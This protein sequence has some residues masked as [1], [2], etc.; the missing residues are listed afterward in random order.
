LDVRDLFDLSGRT[1]IV[2]GGGR[3][4]GRHIGVGLAEAGARVFLASRKL[5]NCEHAAAE[6]VDRGLVAEGVQADVAKPEEV[7]SLVDHVLERSDRIDVL[8]NNAGMVWAADTLDYPLKGWDRVFELNVRGLWLLSQR[9]ARQMR[10]Q[11]GGNIIHITSTSA[12]RGSFEEEQNVVAYN[13]SK[14]AVEALTKD[15]A[16]KLARYG[17]RVNAI[18]PG[19]FDTNMMDYMRQDPG[20]LAR[21]HAAI[22]AQRSGGEDDIKGAVVFLAS[23]AS[24]YVTGHTLIVDGGMLLLARA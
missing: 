2:T 20:R 24:R 14:G 11:G 21:F 15:M 3:G 1:A 17:I 13:A 10:D 23:E 19:P 22:P 4:I 6:L 9:V 12:F 7:D 5:A 8:V 16:V 18:A